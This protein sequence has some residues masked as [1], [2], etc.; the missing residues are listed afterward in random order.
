MRLGPLAQAEG[1]RHVH[2]ETVGSTNAEVLARAEDR[3]WITAGEQASGRG[4]RGRAWAS[5]PGN[6]YASL[7]LRNPADARRAADICFVAA[8][9][10]SDAVFAVAPRAASV[11]SLKWPNDVLIGGAKTA[12]I[13]V[14]GSHD[15]GQFSV[16]TGCG[17]NIVSHPPQT[18][19]PA[20]HLAAHDA[21]V[22]A[23][24]VFAA[25]ADGFATRLAQ[26]RGGAGFG[27][28]REAWL[29]RA[30]GLGRRI[31]VRLPSGDLD[32]VFEALDDDGALILRGDDG[33]SRPVA[34]GEIFFP[35]LGAVSGAS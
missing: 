31:V 9:A 11:L 1:F 23:A 21:T 24:D 28:I 13:L 32:G 15:G 7:L 20:T 4:R 3:L 16:V 5:P 25:L 19:Y 8:L 30:A 12:G 29:S 2:L 34:A 18:P 17:V 27:L 6:L 10:V 14:E 33:T 22:T 35:G 26:W